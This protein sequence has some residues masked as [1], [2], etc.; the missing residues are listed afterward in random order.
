[1]NERSAVSDSDDHIGPS[2]SRD[3]G[4][5]IDSA[6]A[7]ATATARQMLDS[8]I[9]PVR[10]T[11]TT[12]SSS[13]SS[14]SDRRPF[15]RL[16]RLRMGTATAPCLSAP[17]APFAKSDRK[18]AYVSAAFYS[19][20]ALQGIV[21]RLADSAALDAQDRYDRWWQRS[22]Y[23]GGIGRIPDDSGGPPKRQRLETSVPLS[24]PPPPHHHHD[25]QQQ[26]SQEDNQSVHVPSE[27][28]S[29]RAN[30]RQPRG[31]TELSTSAES[32]AIREVTM[33]SQHTAKEIAMCK[34][35]MLEQLKRT[36]G[37]TGS[38]DFLSRLALLRDAYESRGCDARWGADDDAAKVPSSPMDGTWLTLSR[39][40]FSDC[41]GQNGKG[42]CLYSLGRL[43]F[44]MFRP[45]GLQCS[46]QGIFNTVRVHE[47]SHNKSPPSSGHRSTMTFPK[48]L[49][50]EAESARKKPVV[51]DYE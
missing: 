45:T 36:G 19:E 50:R 47:R 9:G 37:D 8:S 17:T 1:M 34:Q 38:H 33:T 4:R 5:P 13:S 11:T 44:G 25:Q 10:T 30:R 41:R 51:R 26:S 12:A 31:R 40:A 6:A 43:A 2:K 22:A 21:P 20:C 18:R 49:R 24:P 3:D 32:F 42:D 48:R 14:S 28:E 16:Q 39:Q 23:R 27:D 7:T 15:F 29:V 35:S 46:V